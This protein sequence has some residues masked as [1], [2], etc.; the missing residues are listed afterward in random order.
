MFTYF[1]IILK[2]KK[3]NNKT[4]EFEKESAV[5]SSED[6]FE[7]NQDYSL[8]EKY[9]KLKPLMIGKKSK[10]NKIK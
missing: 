7:K 1:Y 5:E 6:I 9:N 8:F 2:F 10:K 3:L 4:D